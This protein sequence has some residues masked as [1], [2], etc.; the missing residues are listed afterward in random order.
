MAANN[1]S[2]SFV[3]A[4]LLV[5][6]DIFQPCF[7]LFLQVLIPPGNIEERLREKTD[8]PFKV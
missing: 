8:N 6:P 1:F 3:A 2:K 5:L 7:V 4:V